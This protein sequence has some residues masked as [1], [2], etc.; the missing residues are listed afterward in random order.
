MELKFLLQTAGPSIKKIACQESKELGCNFPFYQYLQAITHL[1]MEN[2]D[3][4]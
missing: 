2:N 1:F 4:F 3:P